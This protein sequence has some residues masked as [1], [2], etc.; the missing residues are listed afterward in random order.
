MVSS[1]AYA[2]DVGLIYLVL[3]GLAYIF[4]A[5]AKRPGTEL[6]IHTSIIESVK[7]TMRA[8]L[9]LGGV[10][11]VSALPFFWT[12]TSIGYLRFDLWYLSFGSFFLWYRRRKKEPKG[13]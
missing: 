5:E 13:R 1:F 4:L 12:L 6:R 8:E 7:R 3:A 9:F 11:A 2:V 10:F